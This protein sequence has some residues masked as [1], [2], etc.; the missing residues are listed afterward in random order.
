MDRRRR[1]DHWV[2]S[3]SRR[4]LNQEEGDV[5]QMMH[6]TSKE[7]KQFSRCAV[8]YSGR[9]AGWQEQNYPEV[10]G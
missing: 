8:D 10:I 1:R 4:E 5:D 3:V 2:A 6:A 7:S 9:V